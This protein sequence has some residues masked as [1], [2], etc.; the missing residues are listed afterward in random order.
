MAGLQMREEFGEAARELGVD[1]FHYL[2]GTVHDAVL[3]EVKEEYL[4]YVWDRGLAIMASPRLLTQFEISLSVP[5]E[6]EA[7]VGPWGAGIGIE[8]WLKAN[9][10]VISAMMGN[11]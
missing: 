4:Q 10:K 6:A 7:K 9:P 8:K 11:K 3:F 2:V 5:I 1:R